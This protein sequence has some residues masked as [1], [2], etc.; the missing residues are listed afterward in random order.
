MCEHIWPVNLILIRVPNKLEPKGNNGPFF[1]YTTHQW[2]LST[3]HH[4]QIHTHTQKHDLPNI[5]PQQ[6][7]QLQAGALIKV[8]KHFINSVSAPATFA[9][10]YF[11]FSNVIIL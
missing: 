6:R 9:C 1:F 10:I 7:A 5:C 2:L 4:T 11:Q 3:H 8:F